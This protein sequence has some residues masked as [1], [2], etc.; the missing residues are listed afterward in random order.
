MG[1][2]IESTIHR[3]LRR[4]PLPVAPPRTA[5]SMAEQ[6]HVS[7]ERLSLDCNELSDG[8]QQVLTG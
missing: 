7:D 5:E 6:L 8:M 2:S 4:H 3:A 1:L